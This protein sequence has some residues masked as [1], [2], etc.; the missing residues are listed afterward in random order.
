MVRFFFANSDDGNPFTEV[1]SLGLGEMTDFTPSAVK[2][3]NTIY[4]YYKG[5]GGNNLWVANST[6]EGN[7]WQGNSAIGIEGVDLASGPSAVVFN[8][9][10]FVFFTHNETVKYYR[11]TDG[12]NYTGSFTVTR[13]G[14]PPM[15]GQL[16]T[17]SSLEVAPVVHNFK[18]YLFYV[19]YGIDNQGNSFNNDIAAVSTN[20][21]NFND[22]N[23]INNGNSIGEKT[24]TGISAISTGEQIILTFSGFYTRKVWEKTNVS[25][26]F[27]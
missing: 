19:K 25:K 9:E 10:I 22:W 8:N 3:G 11:S 16:N 2:F 13:P 27:Q 7:T 14:F 20:T 1:G 24:S 18:L 21:G 5:D 15:G 17:V 12:V 23:N 6:D 4:V 26:P